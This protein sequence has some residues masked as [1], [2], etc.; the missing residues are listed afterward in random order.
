MTVK[1]DAPTVTDQSAYKNQI[2]QANCNTDQAS[3]VEQL[4]T[5]AQ[6]ARILQYLKAGNRLTTLY[7]RHYLNTMHPAGRVMELR[8]AGH[9]IVTHRRKDTDSAGRVHQVAEYVLMPGGEK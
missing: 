2:Q 7:A 9:N 6:R 8:R 5:E 3:N 4:S 1:K